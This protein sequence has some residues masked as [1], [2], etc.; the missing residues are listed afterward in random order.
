LAVLKA[1]HGLSRRKTLVYSQRITGTYELELWLG[2]SGWMEKLRRG[3]QQEK[4]IY[5]VNKQRAAL[6]EPNLFQRF[7]YEVLEQLK[8]SYASFLR[9][10][11]G[12]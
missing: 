7:R 11:T 2:I 4:L 6:I 8:K 9:A 10:T 3:I 12:F 5:Y 1:T